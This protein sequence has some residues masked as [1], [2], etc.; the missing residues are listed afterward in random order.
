MHERSKGGDRPEGGKK[1]CLNFLLA[2]MNS[3]ELALSGVDFF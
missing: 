3:Y 2:L 1:K